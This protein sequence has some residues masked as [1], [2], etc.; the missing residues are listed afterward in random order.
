[1]AIKLNTINNS[2][3][4]L[5][6]HV[7]FHTEA[8][9]LIAEIT[10]DALHLGTIYP[11]Y[12]S[13]V[14]S[15]NDVVNRPTA[16]AETQQIAEADHTRD[17]TVSFIFN[18]TS[19]FAASPSASQRAAAATIA[20]AIRPYHGIRDHEMNRQTAEVDSM[21]AIL[22]ETAVLDALTTL[23]IEYVTQELIKAN[24]D[25]KAA[26]AARDAE[27]LRRQPVK[28]ANTR[29]LRSNTDEQYRCIIETVNAFAIVMPST[30]LTDFIDRM[31]VLIDKYKLV[32]A[33]QG[34]SRKTEKEAE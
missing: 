2:S 19:T 24:S 17:I 22:G 31:N 1:M 8:T 10:A 14:R 16:Y 21:I 30:E 4:T 5:A 18:L 13:A 6:S 26:A 11:T 28:E 32:I 9:D 23:N 7:Q 33:N 3:L 15:E 27:A 12:K 25:F 29:I 34:K 20:A